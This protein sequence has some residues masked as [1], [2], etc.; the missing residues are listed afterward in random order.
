VAG[1][2]STRD[3]QGSFF[4]IAGGSRPDCP[5]CGVPPLGTQG[6]L[7]MV[8]FSQGLV[9][10]VLFLGFFGRQAL[11]FRRGRSPTH[12]AGMC[13]LLFFGL[14]LFVYDTL[15]MPLFIVMIAVALMWR[16]DWRAAAAGDGGGD[17]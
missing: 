1:F 5:A 10:L 2:G 17:P 11:A 13:V 12:L 4:S 16:Q 8:L 15:G 7:W 14:Q 9:G 6:H 3:V